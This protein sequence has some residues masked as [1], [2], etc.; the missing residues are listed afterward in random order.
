[1]SELNGEVVEMNLDARCILTTASTPASRH[2]YVSKQAEY[3]NWLEKEGVDACQPN[4]MINYI[5]VLNDKY[6]PGSM[7]STYSILKKWYK[8]KKTLTSRIGH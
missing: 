1:M 3:I 4:V 6:S 8:I 2:K 5:T 7:W